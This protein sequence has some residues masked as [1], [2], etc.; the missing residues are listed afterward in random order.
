MPSAFG[1]GAAGNHAPVVVGQDNDPLA[2]KG[3]LEQALAGG[4]EVIAVDQR[5]WDGHERYS[6]RMECLTTPHTSKALSSKNRGLR[7][8]IKHAKA[9]PADEPVVEGLMRPYPV[10][11][12]FTAGRYGSRRRSRSQ[13]AG[14]RPG[15]ACAS[16]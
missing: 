12:P 11:H 2:A 6:M 9:A 10:A 16:V 4:I 7:N 5:E 1:L 3:G 8:L 13:P 14:H 15:Q